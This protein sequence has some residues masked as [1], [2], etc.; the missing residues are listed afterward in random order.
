[1][2]IPL[3]GLICV[4]PAPQEAALH[5]Q[6]GHRTSNS[7]TSSLDGS[8]VPVKVE[9]SLDQS[10]KIPSHSNCI[11]KCVPMEAE[12]SPRP[13]TS[14]FWN[15]PENFPKLPLTCSMPAPPPSLAAH[16]DALP[17]MDQTPCFQGSPLTLPPC[18]VAAVCSSLQS[19]PKLSRK[20]SLPSHLC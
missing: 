11:W 17:V 5:M 4:L 7:I 15:I 9:S 18:A 6:H 13:H 14:C 8:D 16:E 1:M 19:I 2:Y 20:M 12:A 10:T 3:F